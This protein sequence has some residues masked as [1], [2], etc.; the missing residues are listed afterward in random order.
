MPHA[1]PGTAYA[2][3][4]QG[5]DRRTASLRRICPAQA[6]A[7]VLVS[8][9]AACGGSPNPPTA[10]AQGGGAATVSAATLAS[11]QANYCRQKGGTIRGEAGPGGVRAMCHLPDHRIAEIGALYRVEVVERL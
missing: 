10:S 2:T 5:R 4:D 8:L 9:A 1:R 6:T 7:L 11:P 3:R